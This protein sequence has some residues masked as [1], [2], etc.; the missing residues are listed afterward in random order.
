MPGL[1]TYMYRDKADTD[2][3]QPVITL[4]RMLVQ[5]VVIGNAWSSAGG[6]GDPR[7]DFKHPGSDGSLDDC[8]TPVQGERPVSRFCL[9][10]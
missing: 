6:T 8:R 1:N 5:K 7:P 3:K 9:G 2:V 10:A 4:I